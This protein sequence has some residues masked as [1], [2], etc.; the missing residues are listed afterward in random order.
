MG[1]S[2]KVRGQLSESSWIRRMFEEG[3]ALR[4]EHGA[5]NVFDLSLGNP[6][7]EP[8]PEFRE[9][10]KRIAD[11][12]TPGTHRYMPNGGFP[13]TRAAVAAG[14]AADTG[15]PFAGDDVIMTCG[16]G[17]AL[18]V[19][20]K[21]LLDPGD[22]VV[23]IA[24]YF[25]E[26]LFY[27][28]NHGGTTRIAHSDEGFLPDPESLESSMTARTKAVLINSPNNPTGVVY[29]AA[30]LDAISTVISEAEA[31]FG[32][33][34]FL[35]SDEPYRKLLFTEDPFPHVFAHH[36]R[37][38]V[39]T[40]HSKDLGLA[41]ERIGY[42]AVNPAYDGRGEFIDAVTFANRTLGFVNAPAIM[43]RI[44]ARL[45]SATVA[46]EEYRRKKD[47]IYRA[48]TAIGYEC[49]EPQGAFYMF[50]KT[51]VPDDE[52]FVTLLRSKLVLTVPGVGFGAPGHFRLSFCVDD[53]TL[54]GS[55][56][57]F[58]AAFEEAASRGGAR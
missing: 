43:Q 46:V 1:I 28:D 56:P 23:I 19:V 32:T 44:V 45:Q 29:P 13:E 40:S 21:A 8:P 38:V 22:E 34:I 25:V 36:A 31:R 48:L 55:V 39:A 35:V 37:S 5:E 52:E 26:Y 18:N 24:P 33:E 50:P 4:A 51:P 17:A 15:L 49:V 2:N 54:E 47:F 16:A 58:K 11:D 12:R 9:E 7:L 14:L 3:I 53:P 42:I 41:G 6:V 57:G 20:L 27:V 30:T 10:L